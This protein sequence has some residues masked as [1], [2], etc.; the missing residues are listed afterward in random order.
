MSYPVVILADTTGSAGEA[1]LALAASQLGPL[2]LSIRRIV[3]VHEAWQVKEAVREAR[4]VG[5]PVFLLLTDET[6]AQQ[7][8]H[9]ASLEGVDCHDVLGTLIAALGGASGA[10]R[11]SN[12]PAALAAERRVVSTEETVQFAVRY[13]DGHTPREALALADV[14]IIGV[15]R[16]SKTPLCLYLARRGMKAVNIP[17][18]PELPPPDELYQ[19]PRNRIVGLAIRTER[20]VELREKRLAGLTHFRAGVAYASRKR[21]LLELD[22]AYR[23]MEKLKCRQLDITDMAVE[24]AA[25]YIADWMKTEG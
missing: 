19:V 15:S 9:A 18:V 5:C 25:H 3:S 10:V 12:L 4:F 23:I 13:D 21:V 1:L 22:Y 6:L 7:A 17:L 24:E 16:T 20:L 14:V 8:R 2:E 11:S